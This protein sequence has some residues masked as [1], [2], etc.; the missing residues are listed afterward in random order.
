MKAAM[1]ARERETDNAEKRRS[2]AIMTDWRGEYC[3][4][5]DPRTWCYRCQC[6]V[7]QH[8]TLMK[9]L[10][11]IL[12]KD[13]APRRRHEKYN[14]SGVTNP[15]QQ[16]HKWAKADS[17]YGIEQFAKRW[18]R[19]A[20]RPGT[21]GTQES[22]SHGY[23]SHA[24]PSRRNTSE[25]VG[26]DEED[27]NSQHRASENDQDSVV[28]APP[29]RQTPPSMAFFNLHTDLLGIADFDSMTKDQITELLD[30]VPHSALCAEVAEL[31]MKRTSL[32]RKLSIFVFCSLF[33]SKGL[34]RVRRLLIEKHRFEEEERQKA[35]EAKLRQAEEE[36]KKAAE[37]AL[38][39]KE[40]FKRRPK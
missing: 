18:L 14:G 7:E 3:T 23:A 26:G 19:V 16:P 38:P 1:K 37:A 12:P 5:K 10:S 27:V 33:L 2:G 21:E 6:F 34:Y 35:E 15:Q 30:Q 36:A 20:Q 29:R 17:Y 22:N 31:E 4:V 40:G 25:G 24:T 13:D 32:K 28:T 11:A 8:E 39:P 9:Q